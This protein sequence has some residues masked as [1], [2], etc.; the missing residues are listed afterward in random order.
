MMSTNGGTE[1][2][3]SDATSCGHTEQ[4]YNGAFSEDWQT[5][6][7][8]LPVVLQQLVLYR[9]PHSHRASSQLL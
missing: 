7:N 3:W 6:G 9:L 2:A 8:A 4:G 5:A 1:V